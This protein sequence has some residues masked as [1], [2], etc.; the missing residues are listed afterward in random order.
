VKR[1]KL[2]VDEAFFEAKPAAGGWFAL[3]FDSSDRIN[4]GHLYG[5]SYVWGTNAVF[6]DLSAWYHIV[7][8]C[9]TTS[10]TNT[11]TGTATDRLRLYVNGTQ[12]SLGVF[13]SPPPASPPAQNADLQVNDTV[14]HYIGRFSATTSYSNFYLANIHFIDGQALTPASFAETDATTG[15]WNPVAYTGSYGTNGFNLLFADNSS[16]TAST[17]GKDTS[18]NGNNWTPNNLS[19]TAGAGNDSL[20]D[21]PTNY[22]TDTGVGGE[23]RGNYAT[24]NPLDT[25]SGATLSNGNLDLA[26][27]TSGYGTSRGTLAVSSGKFYW[28]ILVNSVSSDVANSDPIIGIWSA[29]K[30]LSAN[31]TGGTADSYGYQAAGGN[32]TNNGSLTAYGASFTAGDVISVAL[33]LDAGTLVFYKNGSSQGTAFSSLSGTFAPSAGDSG[34]S[35]SCSLTA[36]FGQRAFAYTAPSG[37]KA[38]CTQNLPAPLVTKSST[39][40]DVI[41]YT[42]T[43]SSLTLPNGSSTPT[44]IAFTPDLVWLKGRS[45]ATDHAIYDSVRDV[46]KDLVSNSTAAETTQTTGLTAFGTNT[47]TVGSLAKLNTSSATYVGWC[48]DAGTSTTT[49]NANAYS[50]GVP[51]ITSQVRANPTAGFSVITYTGNGTAGATIGHGLGVAPAF[52]VVKSRS[53]AGTRWYAYHKYISA[54]PQNDF[55]DLSSTDAK[56]T[57]TTV[58]NNTSPTSSVIT[59]GTDT[60]TNDNT[61]TF[62]CYAWTPV[63]GYSAMS[64]YV[65]TGTSDNAFQYC[66][67]RPRFILLKNASV[68]NS[69]VILDAARSTYNAA[70]D[71][72]GPNSSSAEDSNNAAYSV[73]FLSNGFKVR[74]GNGILGNS[75]DTVIWAA[76]AEAPLN[77]S[78]AR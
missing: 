54:T 62:V 12:Q 70:D 40:F 55:I 14:P 44:S 18:G 31:W 68:T 24:L 52:F 27:P 78:R 4:I 23:V 19:V 60:S 16:N 66:G 51:S 7:A 20:V 39:V 28:E 2:G 63:V 8:V 32:K 37:F 57:A 72:L 65:S 76:F 29:S 30:T 17:L 47:F 53:R 50:A 42:G 56:G 34:Y 3:I 11:I 49:I 38:L 43:G 67:F 21:S 48:W 74:S 58:W 5:I 75:G 41:T 26:T 36:N 9:D 13:G 46:Q 35:G 33:N 69:W 25:L 1:S 10:A 71:W 45:G 6:R 59:F 64:S 77:Y 73:D 61:S 15:A 22:G